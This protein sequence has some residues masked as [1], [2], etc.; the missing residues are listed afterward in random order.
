MFSDEAWRQLPGET[1]KLKTRKLLS[2]LN[3]YRQKNRKCFDFAKVVLNFFACGLFQQFAKLL[4]TLKIKVKIVKRYNQRIKT[5]WVFRRTHTTAY[6][7][8]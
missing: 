2:L 3:L 1:S 7:V 4:H 6:S 8:N 5:K